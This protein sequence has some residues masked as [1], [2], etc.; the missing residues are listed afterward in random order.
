MFE[1]CMEHPDFDLLGSHHDRCLSK[2]LELP[3]LPNIYGL[4]CLDY[5]LPGK[6]PD[7]H[8]NNGIYVKDD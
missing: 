8:Y 2:A 6:V 7:Y 5:C 3:I 4:T 1:I